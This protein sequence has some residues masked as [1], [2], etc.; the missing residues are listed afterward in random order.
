MGG[1]ATIKAEYFNKYKWCYECIQRLCGCGAQ[2]IQGKNR[3][4]LSDYEMK[5]LIINDIITYY[6]H[7]I[8][9]YEKPRKI[10][11]RKKIP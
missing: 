10:I 8:K 1:P 7:R 11:P 6:I 2:D 9:K 5:L 4:I 3:V